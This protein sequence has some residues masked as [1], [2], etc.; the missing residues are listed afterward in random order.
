MCR[1]GWRSRIFCR[2]RFKVSLILLSGACQALPVFFQGHVERVDAEAI[3]QIK[4][5]PD[6]IAVKIFDRLSEC[7]AGS[8]LRHETQG[9]DL[10]QEFRQSRKHVRVLKKTVC[11]GRCP[12][13]RRNLPV[14][15]DMPHE[16]SLPRQKIRIPLPRRITQHRIGIFSVKTQEQAVYGQCVPFIMIKAV[17]I[18]KIRF[19]TGKG[20]VFVKKTRLDRLT[21]GG[22]RSFRKKKVQVTRPLPE[23]KVPN[24]AAADQENALQSLLPDLHQN[25]PNKTGR[26]GFHGNPP[27]S[28][29]V[30]VHP[31]P[32]QVRPNQPRPGDLRSRLSSRLLS[33]HPAEDF[34][35][36]IGI[37]FQRLGDTPD[38]GTG[39]GC[40]HTAVKGGIASRASQSRSH[41][42][43]ERKSTVNHKFF[44][45]VFVA[46]A[47]PGNTGAHNGITDPLRFEDALDVLFVETAVDQN[48]NGRRMKDSGWSFRFSAFLSLS[49]LPL[50]VLIQRSG[51]HVVALRGNFIEPHGLLDVALPLFGKD[52]RF[53]RMSVDKQAEGLSVKQETGFV[54]G[55]RGREDTRC[56]S[57]GASE[58]RILLLCNLKI[59]QPAEKQ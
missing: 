43:L 37:F 30:F 42:A 58:R 18:Y 33:D 10:R 44:V 12:G 20:Q 27:S 52:K 51:K 4:N 14:T 50:Q 55:F 1:D 59:I 38:F 28:G 31:D 2:S 57:H 17:F 15:V 24:R 56:E 54:S 48:R 16:A 19:G 13:I 47:G 5:I 46:R 35:I 25:I 7:P 26:D 34:G 39:Y 23:E 8:L 40:R 6:G 32:G 36:N 41:R 9:N 29:R 45:K 11:L 22:I 21:D 3:V 49:A 53:L